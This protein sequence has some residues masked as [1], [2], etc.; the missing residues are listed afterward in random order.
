MFARMGGELTVTSL[1]TRRV[2]NQSIITY[3]DFPADREDPRK[4]K[5]IYRRP[6]V[7]V[8]IPS[9][10]SAMFSRA[11]STVKCGKVTIQDRKILV[12]S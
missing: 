8:R 9:E 10:L 2:R 1:R 11:Q 12:S 6:P 3:I 5:K 4:G 7:R